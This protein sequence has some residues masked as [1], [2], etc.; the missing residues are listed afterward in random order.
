M[1][2]ILYYLPE[3]ERPNVNQ[4]VEALGIPAGE[5][6]SVAGVGDGPG[7]KPGL[8]IGFGDDRVGYYADDQTWHP[9]AGGDY[10]IGW[11]EKPEPGDLERSELIAGHEVELEGG[12][13]VIPVARS[14]VQGSMLPHRMVLNEEGEWTHR[15]LEAYSKIQGH[16]E[17]VWEQ[18]MQQVEASAND[19]PD[20]DFEPMTDK[21]VAEIAVEALA[22]NYRVSRWEVSALGLLTNAKALEI[23]RALV[24]WPTVVKMMNEYQES[25]Q[26]KTEGQEVSDG[27]N[28]SDG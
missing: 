22:V 1:N 25:K 2:G 24:D 21:E 18:M 13:W 5:S 9:A 19:G 4:T 17:R 8:V 12:K 15:P 28:T 20:D 3:A 11:N 23:C 27:A 6:M 14:E 26:K 7:G 16:A 10:W